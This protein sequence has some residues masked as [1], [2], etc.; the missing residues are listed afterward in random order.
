MLALNDPCA[1]K[2]RVGEEPLRHYVVEGIAFDDGVHVSL[3]ELRSDD[4]SH[5]PAV[6][7]KWAVPWAGY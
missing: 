2:L 7:E 1:R 5:L 3:G 4:Q 6:R